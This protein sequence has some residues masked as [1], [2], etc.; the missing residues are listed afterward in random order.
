MPTSPLRPDP[1]TGT[2]LAAA[3]ERHIAGLPGLS[4]VRAIFV[5]YQ[6]G[7]FMDAA[8]VHVTARHG[9]RRCRCRIDLGDHL[10][11]HAEEALAP[12]RHDFVVYAASGGLD[13]AIGA[14]LH[15]RHGP[16]GLQIGPA[17]DAGPPTETDPKP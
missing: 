11:T 14:R 8:E 9:G 10:A 5:P 3:L 1:I 7:P 15:A 13:A 2:G 4:H 12:G 6:P 16:C 17:A